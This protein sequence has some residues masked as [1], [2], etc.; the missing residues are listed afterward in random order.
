VKLH[1][2]EILILILSLPC[3]WRRLR[4]LEGIVSQV[5]TSHILDVCKVG[6]FCGEEVEIDHVVV[7]QNYSR[8]E[9]V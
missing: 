5:D 4:F 2:R 1:V 7:M 8:T 3:F 6:S 9:C